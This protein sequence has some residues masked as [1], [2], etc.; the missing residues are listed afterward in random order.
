MA[1]GQPA[2]CTLDVFLLL[3]RHDQVLLALWQGTGY[4]DGRWNLPSGKAEHTET[5]VAAVI[6][7]ELGIRLREHEINSPPRS[8]AATAA[9]TSG[10]AC[11]SR[12]PRK[13]RP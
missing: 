7:E 11:S 13:T 10:S 9:P 1:R 2:A 5:A 6:R 3:T 4:A 8:I 12:R